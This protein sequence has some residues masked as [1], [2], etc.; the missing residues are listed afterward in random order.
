MMDALRR[1]SK[2]ASSKELNLKF[3]A[4]APSKE[5]RVATIPTRGLKAA[6]QDAAATSEGQEKARL[7]LKMYPERRLALKKLWI[8]INAKGGGVCKVCSQQC[9][10]GYCQRGRA[11]GYRQPP[12]AHEIFGDT[13]LTRRQLI[14][15]MT[16]DLTPED[17]EM[18]MLLD[19]RVEKKTCSTDLIEKLPVVTGAKLRGEVCGVCLVELEEDEEVKMIPTCGHLYHDVCIRHW[20]TTCKSTCPLDGKELVEADLS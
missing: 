11:S 7:R 3:A 4:T 9:R 16:R 5:L 2:S 12:G 19:E 6:I 17:Y 10:G 18:L 13:G 14:D 15:L 8:D 1:R 20:L